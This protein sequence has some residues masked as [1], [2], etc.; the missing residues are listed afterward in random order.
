MKV[1]LDNA[2]TTPVDERVIELMTKVLKENYGNP[3]SIHEHGRKSRTLIEKSRKKV[4]AALGVSPGEILFT[5]GGTEADNMALNCAV[6]DLGCTHIITSPIEHHAVLY[7]AERLATCD[8]VQLSLVEILPNGHI[9]TEHLK[10]LLEEHSD[11]KTLVSLMHANNEIGNMI[12]LAEIG[13]ICKEHDAYFH[14]DTVQT[15]GHW[16]VK[17]KECGV[18]FMAASAHKFNGPKGVGFIFVDENVQVKPMILG[19][20][21]ERNMR[22]GTEN[23]VGI[24]GLAKSLEISIAE[25]DEL[26]ERVIGFRKHMIS[27]LQAEIEGVVINGDY[28]GLTNYIP[29]NV[30]FPA[31]NDGEMLLFN[32]DIAGVSASGGSACSSGSNIGSHVMRAINADSSKTSIRFSFGKQNTLEEV[33]YTVDRLVELFQGAKKEVSA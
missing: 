29:L 14:S 15:I 23:L 18:H 12:D 27:R 8:E 32:L 20:S 1:Y 3:S 26:K 7:T 25:M 9:N 24:V 21:Q 33:D 2:A 4:A 11:K 16:D 6:K 19:G 31:T 28:D 5:S 30:S 22:G 13:A 17:P 10:Q